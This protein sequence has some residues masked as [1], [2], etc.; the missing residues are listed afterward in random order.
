MFLNSVT[1]YVFVCLPPSQQDGITIGFTAKYIFSFF[2][3]LPQK[4]R[5]QTESIAW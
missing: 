2:V 1:K 5:Q 4:G 3:C